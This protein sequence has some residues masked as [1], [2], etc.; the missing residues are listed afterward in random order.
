MR[1]NQTPPRMGRGESNKKSNHGIHGI[2]GKKTKEEEKE[3][4]RSPG[5][6]FSLVLLSSVVAEHSCHRKGWFSQGLGYPVGFSPVLARADGPWTAG[7]PPV[8]TSNPLRTWQ[9][10]SDTTHQSRNHAATVDD[11]HGA[12]QRRV[13]GLRWIDAHLAEKRVQ[14]VLD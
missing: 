9:E 13:V 6:V 11:R 4:K 8:A 12:A 10:C 3:E 14:D 1:P 7:K 2:H 5:V